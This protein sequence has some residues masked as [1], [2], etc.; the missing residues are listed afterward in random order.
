MPETELMLILN[1]TVATTPHD[2]ESHE[3][4]FEQED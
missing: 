1:D 4:V 2:W 3:V